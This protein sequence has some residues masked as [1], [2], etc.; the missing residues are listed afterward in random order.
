MDFQDQGQN[1]VPLGGQNNI[2][3]SIRPVRQK[4]NSMATAALVTAVIGCVSTFIILPVY[5]PCVFG[6]ISIVLALLSKGAQPHFS[7]R[8]F[9]GVITSVC[10]II[11]NVFIFIFCFYLVFNVPEFREQF[12]QTYEQLYGESFDDTLEHILEDR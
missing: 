10:S 2:P 5:L 6:G 7:R 3:V 11:L 12:N 4:E 9:A 1:Q 8:A